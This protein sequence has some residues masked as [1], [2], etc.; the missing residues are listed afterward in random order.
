MARIAGI[1]LDR[2]AN[3]TIKKVTFDLKKHGEIINPIL[4]KMGVIEEDEF[5]KKWSKGVTGDELR[6]K[7]HKRI[8]GWWG[9]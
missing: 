1:Q 8:E 7:L 4:E 9:K 5:E 6:A 3:G 2:A